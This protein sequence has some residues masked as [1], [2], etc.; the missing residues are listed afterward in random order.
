MTN[1]ELKRIINQ[2]GVWINGE[3]CKV[4]E[5]IDFPVFSIVFF[6]KGARKTTIW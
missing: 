1:G 3:T 6:P 5:L 4:Q 2:G